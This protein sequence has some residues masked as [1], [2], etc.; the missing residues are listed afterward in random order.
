MASFTRSVYGLFAIV[1]ASAVSHAAEP[2]P[3]TLY[4]IGESITTMGST[5][6]RHPYVVARTTNESAKTIT[7]TVV[8]YE[9]SGF[10]ENSSVLTIDGNR[11]AMRTST[12]TVT[13]SGELTGTPWHWTFLRGEFKV[14]S[15]GM[16]IVDYNFFADPA[17]VM[18]HKDFYLKR[19]SSD[20]RL[21]MQEDVVLHM[22]EKTTFDAKRAEL[23]KQ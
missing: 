8:S 1:I 2:N 7:E 21:L 5:V 20:E 14:A 4:Y 16:R 15:Q 23:L 9:Q 13:G 19:D 10:K 6:T 18:G 22:V 17:A 3:V 11:F 12:G